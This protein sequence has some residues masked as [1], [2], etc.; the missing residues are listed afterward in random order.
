[1]SQENV[2]AIRR[3]FEAY[4][5]P[6]DS[7]VF[8]DICAPDVV[9]DMSRS[10]FPEA[11]IYHG[12]D[13]VR[14]WLRGLRDDTGATNLARTDELLVNVLEICTPILCPWEQKVNAYFAFNWEGKEESTLN[15][16]P[17]LRRPRQRAGRL[18]G[19]GRPK[20]DQGHDQAMTTWA[21]EEL[22]TPASARRSDSTTSLARDA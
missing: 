2:E 5:R 3:L 9:W 17:A 18:S 11:R 15:E 1:V 8:L 21:N 20:V 6:S 22:E 7:E 19:D 10:P 14:E 16:E 4:S 13:G 12:L